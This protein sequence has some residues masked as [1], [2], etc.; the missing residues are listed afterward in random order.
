MLFALLAIAVACLG[1]F[2]LSAFIAQKRIREISIR[3]VLGAGVSQL[4]VLLTA[5]FAKIILLAN[6][7]AWPV[8]AVLMHR[9]LEG[10]AHRISLNIWIFISAGMIVLILG[11]IT[12][13]YYALRA[14]AANPAEVLAAE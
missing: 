12:V 8:V 3:K 1:L 6:L 7:V 11:I 2:G 14:A 10:F 9:W 13:S 5:D 4:L